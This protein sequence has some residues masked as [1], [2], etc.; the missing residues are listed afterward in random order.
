MNLKPSCLALI[1]GLLIADVSSARLHCQP[2]NDSEL[3][4]VRD[5][6]WRAWFSDDEKTL[7]TLVPPDTIVISGGEKKW[8]HQAE[9]FQSAAEFRSNGNRLIRLEFPHT[10]IQ[11]FGDVAVVW[12]DYLVETEAQGKHSVSTGR[13]SEIFVRQNGQWVNPG[14]HTDSTK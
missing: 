5:A 12:S 6:V 7:H 4:Q 10:E 9:V 13:A 1:F 8:K 3:L 2:Q 14:W 11:H